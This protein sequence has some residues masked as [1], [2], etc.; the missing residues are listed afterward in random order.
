MWA[1]FVVLSLANLVAVAHGYAPSG[2][3]RS[4]GS[5]VRLKRG[6]PTTSSILKCQSEK[7]PPK[8]P[9]KAPVAKRKTAPKRKPATKRKPAKKTEELENEGPSRT[10]D[11]AILKKVQEIEKEKKIKSV[12]KR[13]EEE[14]ASSGSSSAGGEV[15]TGSGK[16]SPIKSTASTTGFRE[17]DEEEDP[18]M[19]PFFMPPPPGV[20]DSDFFGSGDVTDSN[21]AGQGEWSDWNEDANYFD[22]E[23]DDDPGY[24]GYSKDKSRGRAVGKANKG[25]TNLF[26]SRA[27]YA[28]ISDT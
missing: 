2:S 27:Y 4:V 6:N 17:I 16:W 21:K 26:P 18:F 13:N 23:E 25:S 7:D 5:F 8:S 10:L 28:T 14:K 3:L 15:V 12:E 19:D 9:K 24:S 11:A 22:D 20:S 1:W